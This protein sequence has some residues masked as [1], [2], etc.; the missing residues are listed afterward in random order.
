M[1]S[2]YTTNGVTG[3]NYINELLLDEDS[4]GVC[5]ACETD[6]EAIVAFENS[7][8]QVYWADM[9]GTTID[10]YSIKW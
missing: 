6:D 7:F 8:I 5:D 4:L 1:R 9:G 10:E 3:S 2:W